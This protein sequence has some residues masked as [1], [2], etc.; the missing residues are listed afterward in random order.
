MASGS[1]FTFKNPM[2]N[3][4]ARWSGGKKL[5]VFFLW[6]LLIIPIYMLFEQTGGN[7]P[8][9]VQIIFLS[10]Y[11]VLSMNY[12][13]CALI[14][15]LHDPLG[16]EDHMFSGIFF[17]ITVCLAVIVSAQAIPNSSGSVLEPYHEMMSGTS[18][19]GQY[20]VVFYGEKKNIFSGTDAD[21]YLVSLESDSPERWLVCQFKSESRF[22]LAW[23]DNDHFWVNRNP[24]SVEEIIAAP[25]E[26]TNNTQ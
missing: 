8:A 11:A 9:W 2:L 14:S 3:L 26:G 17:I 12:I 19:D 22:Q 18:E 24:Y 21:V 1:S 20:S 25:S 16:S 13:V 15:A 23:E 6:M 5:G 7:V 10:A 4:L